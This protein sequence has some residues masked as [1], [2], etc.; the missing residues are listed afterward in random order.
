VNG[1]RLSARVADTRNDAG[2]MSPI[3]SRIF[4]ASA[5]KS[6]GPWFAYEKLATPKTRPSRWR[7]SSHGESGRSSSSIRPIDD[8]TDATCSPA[9]AVLMFRTS[10]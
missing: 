6:C 1:S 4:A 5:V 2:V 9:S 10:S 8:R 3:S 7:T